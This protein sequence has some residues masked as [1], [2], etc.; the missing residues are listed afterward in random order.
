METVQFKYVCHSE[1]HFRLGIK[2]DH[3][4]VDDF[5]EIPFS[6]LVTHHDPCDFHINP[7][8]VTSPCQISCSVGEAKSFTRQQ[9]ILKV[10]KDAINYMYPFSIYF[11]LLCT[12]IFMS[13]LQCTKCLDAWK[14]RA[15]IVLRECDR[16]PVKVY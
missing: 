15:V 9:P 4:R 12:V 11:H 10:I 16:G 13:C 6:F 2:D 8:T 7:R 1:Q 3:S 5:C 14:H